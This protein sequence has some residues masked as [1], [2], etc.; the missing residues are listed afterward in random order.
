MLS[1]IFKP[2]PGFQA[3]TLAASFL[4]PHTQ[5]KPNSLMPENQAYC[6]DA[7][8]WVSL[9][10]FP[11]RMFCQLSILPL[12]LHLPD[13]FKPTC[14]LIIFGRLVVERYIQTLPRFPGRHSG[15][16]F[17][18]SCFPILK[19]NP[20]ASCQRI[21]PI[22]QMTHVGFLCFPFPSECF[23]RYLYFPFSS[24]CRTRSNQPVI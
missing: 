13:P 2:F 10:S 8:R 23:A 22:V 9:L 19:R 24:I 11:I 7:P 20:T 21:R 4:F 18:V 14:D 16:L 12:F 5:A 17:P 6:T 3:G 1:G 15:S